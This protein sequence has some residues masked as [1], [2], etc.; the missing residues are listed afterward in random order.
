MFPY[1]ELVPKISSTLSVKL[2]ILRLTNNRLK[3]VV[4]RMWH[5]VALLRTDGSVEHI[6]PIIRVARIGYLGTPLAV[7]NS[8][9]TL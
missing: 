8:R 5:R 9:S 4:S 1:V 2:G 7:T 3:N 6:A